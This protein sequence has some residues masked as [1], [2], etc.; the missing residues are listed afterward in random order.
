[1]G[2]VR[3]VE[4]FNGVLL[5]TVIS[6]EPGRRFDIDLRV[7][8]SGREFFDHWVE[9]GTSTFVLDDAPGGTALT[10]RTTY[11][12]RAFPRWYFRPAERLLG[13]AVQQAMLDG[14]AAGL[15]GRQHKNTLLEAALP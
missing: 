15:S 14:Y 3:R 5:A 1:V 4:F 6:S 12:P 11:R 2:D 8:Q 13:C 7:E 9:L 10:H